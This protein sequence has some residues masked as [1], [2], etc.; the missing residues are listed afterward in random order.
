MNFFKKAL[1]SLL[2]VLF[3]A[4]IPVVAAVN[5]T[6]EWLL[7]D[8]DVNYFRY[9]LEGELDNAWTVVPSS[10]T[11]FELANVDGSI[12]HTLYLQQSY[13]GKNWSA[14]AIAVSTPI[15]VEEVVEEVPVVEE[16]ALVTPVVEEV[17]VAE[18]APTAV[19]EKAVVVE[20]KAIV[21]EAN[22]VVAEETPI[23]VAEKAPIVEATDIV[24]EEPVVA[25]EEPVK[26]LPVVVQPI[27]AVKNNDFAF[28]LT[29][30]AGV[31]YKFNTPAIVNDKLGIKG[32]IG[33]GLEN[34]I[35]IG[36]TSGLGLWFDTFALLDGAKSQS[37]FGDYFKL[38]NY[39][40]VLGLDGML[41]YNLNVN[42][43]KFIL[44]AGADFRV[45]SGSNPYSSGSFA[46]FGKNIG[47]TYNIVGMGQFRYQFTNVFSMGLDAR[48]AYS[49]DKKMSEVG[50]T[51]SFGFSF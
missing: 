3:V 44:G 49:I 27:K 47:W 37:S 10:V 48:Y 38:S 9:Q 6:W 18:V 2:I 8:M 22:P 1:I 28:T 35:R 29:F 17:P 20:E 26:E 39:S 30:D 40:K 34:V 36:N 21:A 45:M 33:Y 7:D 11:T 15:P 31:V 13:D 5:V 12:E 42:K 14:S 4:I 50:G 46:L 19:E 23:I 25:K 51:L 24:K 32:N 16:P 41:T 43:M